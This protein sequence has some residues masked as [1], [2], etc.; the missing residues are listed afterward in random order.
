MFKKGL[1][2]I[3]PPMAALAHIGLI[4]LALIMLYP[5]I[6]MVLA[7]LRPQA[8]IFLDKSL[9][10]NN[11]TLENYI[12]GWNFFGDTTFATFFVNSFIISG[13]AIVGNVMAACLCG[14][15]F[16]RLKFKWQSLWFAIMIGSMMLP[17]HAQLI[18]QYILFVKIGWVNTFLPL[19]VPKFLATDSFF[20]FLMVQFMRTLP[21]EL[22]QAA[23][24]DGAS[25]WQ[26]FTRIILPLCVPAIVTT[27]IFTFINT[28]NDFLSQLIY[29]SGLD[30]M[31][32]SLAL[33]LFI[34]AGEVTRISAAC[35]PWPH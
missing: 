27:S 10:P 7:S 28:Y 26:R 3:S 34:D 5:V 9:V 21:R 11:W 32:V 35:L 30:N 6:W 29:L 12:N 2:K 15:A 25:Y 22:E 23:M 18:P 33:R 20:I 1:G 13:L 8:E 4:I 16:A 14:Y 19:V 24:I 17:F 31:T